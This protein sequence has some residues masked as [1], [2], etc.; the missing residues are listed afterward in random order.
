MSDEQL[1]QTCDVLHAQ[2][3][4]L[5]AELMLHSARLRHLAREV[6]AP[7]DHWDSLEERRAVWQA[8]WGSLAR[9]VK[10][11]H[12]DLNDGQVAVLAFGLVQLAHGHDELYQAK[13]RFEM[14]L[15]GRVPEHVIA[16]IRGAL[17][18]PR[19]DRT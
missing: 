18:V 14:Q 6:A 2:Y 16:L 17:A 19:K 12:G 10:R 8:R 15:W 11:E 9:R 7:Y 1:R 4:L 3:K 5:H 13:G